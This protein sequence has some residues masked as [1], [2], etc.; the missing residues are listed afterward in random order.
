MAAVLGVNATKA[1]AGFIG[2]NILSQGQ[3]GSGLKVMVDTYEASALATASTITMGTA[4]PV[5]ATIVDVI[6][7]WDDMGSTVTFKAGDAA[8]DDRYIVASTDVTTANGKASISNI[9]G[10]GYVIT[11]TNDTQIIVTT[12]GT[13]TGT[14]SMTVLYAL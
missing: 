13:W 1:A 14:F 12:A 4:L 2:S 8:D 9:A 3:A 5:G 10:R 7:Q 6:F 11:G